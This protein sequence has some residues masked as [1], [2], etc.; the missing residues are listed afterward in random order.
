MIPRQMSILG[1]FIWEFFI[2]SNYAIHS[3]KKLYKNRI[4]SIWL[5]IILI[6]SQN[7]MKTP[8]YFSF[9]VFITV[10]FCLYFIK[11]KFN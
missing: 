1:V 7:I 3:D 9:T 10:F 6:P 2:E 5:D 11:T 4:I 8:L